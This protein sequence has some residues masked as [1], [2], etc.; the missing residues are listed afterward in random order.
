MTFCADSSSVERSA[1]QSRDG[2]S[3]PTS[4][5]HFK[6]GSIRDFDSL[7]LRH[8]LGRRPSVVRFCAGAYAAGQL[9]GFISFGEPPRETCKRYGGRVFELSR[10]FLDD[11]CGPNSETRFIGWAMREVRRLFPQVVGV[12]SYADPSAGHKGTIYKA[13]NFKSDG[14]TDDERKS[15]R[16]DYYGVTDGK[17]YSR[18]SHVLEGTQIERRPR[19]SK[20]RYFYRFSLPQPAQPVAQQEA[21]TV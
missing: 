3:I 11:A 4:A 8:Y 2:G 13:S 19:V 17:K 18:R 14:R 1:H 16:C 21:K 12:V 5:L 15:P 20:H 10:L 6:A 9:L 7:V